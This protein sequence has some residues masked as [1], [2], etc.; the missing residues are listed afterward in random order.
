MLGLLTEP[1]GSVATVTPM[2]MTSPAPC[3]APVVEVPI[4]GTC[5][6]TDAPDACAGC[7]DASDIVYRDNVTVDK[8]MDAPIAHH[9]EP[10]QF[11][12]WAVEGD[13]ATWPATTDSETWEAWQVGNTEYEGDDDADVLAN[14]AAV[15]PADHIVDVNA[16]VEPFEPTDADRRDAAAAFASMD[17]QS[18]LDRSETL[19][20]EGLIAHQIEFYRGWSSGAG[21]MIADHLEIMLF[22]LRYTGASTPAAYKVASE[23]V[24]SEARETWRRAGFEDAKATFSPEL[25]P[26]GRMA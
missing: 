2:G 9:P 10:D 22:K 5:C 20:L 16:M 25:D 15:E 7:V 24:D 12:P 19:T 18:Y 21:A 3:P 1:I 17:A 26:C 6:P 8:S 11:D 23:Q 13:P 4:L 14:T